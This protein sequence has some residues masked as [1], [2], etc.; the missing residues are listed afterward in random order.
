MEAQTVPSRKF[1]VQQAALTV[2]HAEYPATI[3]LYGRAYTADRLAKLIES[4][5]TE[6]REFCW[7]VQVEFRRR[8]RASLDLKVAA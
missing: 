5:F 4:D 3:T 1:Q 7:E 8:A 6:G 2:L